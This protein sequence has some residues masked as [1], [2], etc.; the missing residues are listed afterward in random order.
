MPDAAPD[1]AFLLDAGSGIFRLIGR[2]LPPKLHI[3]LSHAHLDHT[4]GLTFL[5]DVLYGQITQVTLH[6]TAPVLEAVRHHLFA[7]PLFPV[8]FEQR[9]HLIE[10][11]TEFW[12]EGVQIQT[13]SLTHPGGSTGFR[14]DWPAS[15]TYSSTRKAASLAYVTD[16]AGDGL[17][18]DSIQNLDVLIHERNFSDALPELAVASGHCT[19][20]DV[21]KVAQEVRPR[22]L[23]LT[24]FNPLPTNDPAE[25]DDLAQQFPTAIFARDEQVVTF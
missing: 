7:A 15:S 5:L 14:F 10:H 22:Q 11:G 19:S 3:F 13:F 24:H 17:Y 20:S 18:L 9:T 4:Q 16:T 2:D 12:V 25:E 21:A 1:C 23:V 8:P 6:A